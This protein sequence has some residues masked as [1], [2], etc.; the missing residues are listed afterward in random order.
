M[1]PVRL[2]AARGTGHWGASG[3]G[4]GRLRHRAIVAHRPRSLLRRITSFNRRLAMSRLSLLLGIAAA[5]CVVG[6][7]Q[8]QQS[9]VQVGVLE[10]RG[11]ASIGFIVGSVT[12]LGCVLRADGRRTSPMSPPSARSGSTSA[13]PRKPRWPGRVFAPVERARPRR[14]RRQLRRRAGLG[15]GRR[16]RRRQRAGRR[17]GQ[18]DRAAAA[19]PAGPDRPQRRGRTGRSGI[20]SGS[21]S[22]RC[23]AAP[24]SLSN[25]DAARS[26]RWRSCAAV[27]APMSLIL[28]KT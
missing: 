22:E 11:G 23:A 9:R 25:D 16:R 2:A 6:S 18:F 14:P 19:Q 7:A 5:G 26:H 13:S 4:I 8:A 21:L 24:A 27:R 3:Q 15:H 20:A 10:C 1:E 12:N 28:L 17:L